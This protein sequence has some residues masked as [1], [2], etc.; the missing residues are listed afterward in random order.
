MFY[1]PVSGDSGLFHMPGSGDS[2]VRY[3]QIKQVVSVYIGMFFSFDTDCLYLDTDMFYLS[4][5]TPRYRQIKQVVSVFQVI[6]ALI[7]TDY[8][9]PVIALYLDTGMLYLYFIQLQPNFFLS[10]SD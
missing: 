5:L 4:V 10:V 3:I 2:G 6:G 7:Q 9:Q 1:M 8:A